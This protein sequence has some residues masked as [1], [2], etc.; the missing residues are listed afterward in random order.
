MPKDTRTNGGGHG[1][2]LCHRNLAH[3]CVHIR[4]YVSISLALFPSLSISLSLSPYCHLFLSPYCHLSLSSYFHTSLTLSLF[5][6]SPSLSLSLSL[7]TLSPHSS[8]SLFL[9]PIAIPLSLLTLSPHPSISLYLT[10]AVS[11][12][13]RIISLVA[14]RRVILPRPGR[15]GRRPSSRVGVVGAVD[16]SR[17]PRARRHYIKISPRLRV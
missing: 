10:L 1:R 13:A 11:L 8:I 12:S 17:L 15:C 4:P 9:H 2:N 5:T 7:L 6:L 16:R 3:L 14:L